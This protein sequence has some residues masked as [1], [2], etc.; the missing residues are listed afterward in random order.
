MISLVK[1][2]VVRGASFRRVST[3]EQK[4]YGN[5][6][7]SQLSRIKGVAERSGIKLIADYGGAEHAMP[8]YERAEFNRMIDDAVAGKFDA[9]FVADIS[10]W[11]RDTVA[12]EQAVRRLKKCRI[13]LFIGDSEYD[14]RS[15]TAQLMLTM[16]TK[17]SEGE[18]NDRIDQSA[19]SRIELAAKGFVTSGHPPFGRYIEAKLA[20]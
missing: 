2:S 4:E 3:E 8:G 17:N 18:T 7:S 14:L 20:G 9:I 19:F 6:L 5:S 12:S 1:N 15:R 16:A 10:R 11:S 13:R